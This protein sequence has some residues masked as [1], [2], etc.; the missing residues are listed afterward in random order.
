MGAPLDPLYLIPA[1][2]L[3]EVPQDLVLSASQ[4]AASFSSLLSWTAYLGCEDDVDD[5]DEV[6]MQR[7]TSDM[8]NEL[9]WI[10]GSAGIDDFQPLERSGPLRIPPGETCDFLS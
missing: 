8:D 6:W 1:V 4:A 10:H 5:Y 9:K 3:R 2:G 7:N